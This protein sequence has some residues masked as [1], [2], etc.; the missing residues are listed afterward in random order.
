MFGCGAE[1][2]VELAQLLFHLREG[3]GVH[4]RILSATP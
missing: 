3:F 1:P 2:L 4:A